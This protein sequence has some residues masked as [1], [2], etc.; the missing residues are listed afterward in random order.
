M[1]GPCRLWL[2][3]QGCAADARVGGLS[4]HRRRLAPGARGAVLG[5]LLVEEG[6][7]GAP[8]IVQELAE[9]ALRAAALRARHDREEGDGAGRVIGPA[10]LD[11]R[12]VADPL[13]KTPADLLLQA[14]HPLGDVLADRDGDV[15]AAER[16][17]DVAVTGE[18]GYFH[19]TLLVVVA[20][21]LPRI[22][23]YFVPVNYFTL[24]QA[25]ARPD[26]KPS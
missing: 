14:L 13:V 4:A 23:L 11:G 7:D 24:L 10:G 21:I 5:P 20:G 18:L 17:R 15:I 22:L 26:I 6:P 25:Q 8:R 19:G 1:P 9:A 2:A 3:A 12:T 16:E